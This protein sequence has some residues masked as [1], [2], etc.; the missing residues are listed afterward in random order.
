MKINIDGRCSNG[1]ALSVEEIE[2]MYRSFGYLVG[3]YN[4]DYPS[5]E[6]FPHMWVMRCGHECHS[7]GRPSFLCC[8]CGGAS[9]YVCDICLARRGIKEAK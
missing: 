8:E 9:R 6:S 2:D 3:V 7:L 1:P 5:V 4:L